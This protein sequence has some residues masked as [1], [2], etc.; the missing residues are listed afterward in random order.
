MVKK[1]NETVGIIREQNRE[2]LFWCFM[3]LHKFMT[4]LHL[5]SWAQSGLSVS[6]KMKWK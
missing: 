1:A 4:C 3:P 5:E 6:K 2:H